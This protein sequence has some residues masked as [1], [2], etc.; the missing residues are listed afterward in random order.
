MRVTPARLFAALSL[1]LVLLGCSGKTAP[2][3]QVAPP[4]PAPSTI[5]PAAPADPVADVE[6]DQVSLDAIED[7]RPL[8][9]PRAETGRYICERCGFVYDPAKNSGVAFKDLPADW[10]CPKCGAPKSEFVPQD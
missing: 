9:A 10:K 1:T 7:T 5:V 6:A 4:G 3:P 8:I 2:A